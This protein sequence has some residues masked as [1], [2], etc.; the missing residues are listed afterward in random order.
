M[1]TE[2][3]RQHLPRFPISEIGTQETR[4]HGATKSR[5]GSMPGGNVVEMNGAAETQ[6]T[7][8]T[9]A[10]Y[11]EH[12]LGIRKGPQGGAGGSRKDS[13]SDDAQRSQAGFL[14]SAWLDAY[15]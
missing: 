9:T 2:L 13:P 3:P 8:R 1:K 11:H 4:K 15:R 7:S 6:L 10:A 14:G 5:S 12:R